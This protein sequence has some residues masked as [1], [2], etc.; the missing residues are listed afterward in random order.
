MKLF[1]YFETTEILINFKMR[2]IAKATKMF[3]DIFSEEPK[4]SVDFPSRLF[5]TILRVPAKPLAMKASQT[6]LTVVVVVP[7][8]LVA[9]PPTGDLGVELLDEVA[10][11]LG[12]VRLH[13]VPLQQAHLRE[14]RVAPAPQDCT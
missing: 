10:V 4:Q 2:K 5:E 14:A 13:R 12:P 11:L 3:Y 9:V 1:L 6:G 8:V 7:L